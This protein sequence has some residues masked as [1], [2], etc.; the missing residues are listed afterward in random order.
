M[1][2][3]R[4]FLRHLYWRLEDVLDPDTI[5]SHRVYAELV[6]DVIQ[7]DSAWLEVGC[8]HDVFVPWV[9]SAVDLTE[10]CS[11]VVGIDYDFDSLRKN[12]LIQNRVVGD[13]LAL[14]CCDRTFD[15]ITA[16]MVMEHV[17]D[18]VKALQSIDRLL[19]PDGVFIFHTP[20]YWHYWTFF[21][22]LVPQKL[23]NKLIE[24]VEQRSE[25]DVFPTFYRLN[26][27]KSITRAANKAGL[28]IR[29]LHRVSSSSS[30]AIF[31]LGPL[32]VFHLLFRRLTRWKLLENFRDNFIV[33]L[34]KPAI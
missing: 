9:R 8:G 17:A 13:L 32:I 33:V 2:E 3:L 11:F 19:K 14:P 28:R 15:H 20:N 34:E 7:P 10:K 29:H 5:D 21:N 27:V 26:T 18:P 23:K 30:G 24:F 4:K 25:D 12:H 31:L 22:S 16:N 1:P 6:R